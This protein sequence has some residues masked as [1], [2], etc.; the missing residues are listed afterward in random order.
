MEGGGALAALEAMKAH[1]QEVG[2]QVGTG[3][4][5][6]GDW[7]QAGGQTEALPVPAP[8]MTHLALQFLFFPSLCNHVS[9]SHTPEY[10]VL[11]PLLFL[12]LIF[13]N[14][15]FVGIWRGGGLG[16]ADGA[17]LGFGEILTPL[18][19]LSTPCWEVSGAEL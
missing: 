12:C 13:P 11:T 15:P 16:R 6:A 1:P 18:W 14:R 8:I 19:T 7:W 17:L 10:T 9:T 5:G 2:V 3:K 4:I